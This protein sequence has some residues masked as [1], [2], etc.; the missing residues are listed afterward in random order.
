M[1]G[2]SDPVHDLRDGTGRD[3][4]VPVLPPLLMS[5]SGRYTW[6]P[7]PGPGPIL[8]GREDLRL[9]V[10]GR[11]PRMVASGTVSQHPAA[12]FH[13]IANLT[14]IAPNAYSGSIWYRDGDST[15]LPHS[16]VSITVVRSLF[17]HLRRATVRF[18]GGT[19]PERTRTFTFA[20]SAW[21]CRPSC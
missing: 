6:Q 4:P 20:G 16:H 14:R 19:A 13:W 12:R 5:A 8:R 7:T 10:G 1:T 18:G 9:D 3:L 2:T 21:R 11:C 17:P 15:L